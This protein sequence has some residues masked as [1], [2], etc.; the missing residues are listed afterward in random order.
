MDLKSMTGLAL[1]QAFAQVQLPTP[2]MAK[3][4]P[5]QPLE[6]EFGRILS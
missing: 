5:M 4:I 1:M 6:V 3:T 2:T